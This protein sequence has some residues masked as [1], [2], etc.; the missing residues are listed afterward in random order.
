MIIGLSYLY[1]YC[2]YLNIKHKLEESRILLK[3]VIGYLI[4]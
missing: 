1:I 4:E 3:A 2:L